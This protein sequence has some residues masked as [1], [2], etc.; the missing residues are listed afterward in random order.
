MTNPFGDSFPSE[1]PVSVPPHDSL[2]PSDHFADKAPAAPIGP[3]RYV[4]HV[5]ALSILN[6]AQAGAEILA[7]GGCLVFA[8]LLPTFFSIQKAAPNQ[9]GA[10]MPEAMSWM[11]VGVYGVMGVVML[12]VGI[13]RLV[14]GLRNFQ[15][16]SRYLGIA[17][18]SLGMLTIFFIFCLP[19]AL[20]L[21]I[22][23]LFVLIDPDVAAAFDA[24]RN[25]ATV[26]DVL[27]GR[28]K[29]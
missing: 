6:V 17:S 29:N 4:R 8:L 27:A 16:K 12:S 3:G 10:P 25:G 26:D 23:G 15:F 1:D 13:T 20:A 2:E 9:A 11:A 7:A 22:Y 28:A 21:M 18:L 5:R 19:T 14:A 24:R